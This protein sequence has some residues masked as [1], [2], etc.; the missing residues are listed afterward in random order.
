[1]KYVAFF[2]GLCFAFFASLSGSAKGT[3]IK[4]KE[5]AHCIETCRDYKKCCE[6]HCGDKLSTEIVFLCQECISHICEANCDLAHFKKQDKNRLV[7]RYEHR[8]KPAQPG[9]A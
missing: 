9:G 4:D 3:Q 2:L 7:T 5:H 1:M 6:T 8:I